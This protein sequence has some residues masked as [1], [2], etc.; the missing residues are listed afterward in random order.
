MRAG[1]AEAVITGTF[2]T[3]LCGS[4]PTLGPHSL[5]SGW[6]AN[7]LPEASTGTNGGVLFLEAVPDFC[8]G[9][10]LLLEFADRG[11]AGHHV[12]RV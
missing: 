9:E 6:I 5:T 12:G 7:E 2:R 11:A 1:S 4:I 10:A 8:Q 3:G